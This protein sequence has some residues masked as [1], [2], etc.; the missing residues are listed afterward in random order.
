MS[1]TV[2][3]GEKVNCVLCGHNGNRNGTFFINLNQ[4][5]IDEEVKI[6]NKE[7]V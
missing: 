4:I 3:I 5:S 6:L 2:G 7:G 1:E